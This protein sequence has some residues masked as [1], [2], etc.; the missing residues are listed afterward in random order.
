[1]IFRIVTNTKGS[2]KTM[3]KSA[4]MK[5]VAGVAAVAAAFTF[6]ISNSTKPETDISND[7]P[8]VSDD[9]S[10]SE[11]STEKEKNIVSESAKNSFV[12]R[13]SADSVDDLNFNNSDIVIK[14]GDYGVNNFLGLDFEVS[15]ENIS[16]VL[17][18]VTGGSLC[19]VIK[20]VSSEPANFGNEEKY[21]HQFSETTDDKVSFN[22]YEMTYAGSE[23]SEKYDGNKNQK[24]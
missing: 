11:Q 1:M 6:V 12:L 24:I 17:V 22:N 20:T 3:K 10:I 18:S 5:T 9:N 8:V 14:K 7:I 19:K 2:E 13:V 21:V 15:G 4:I 23:I 16:E